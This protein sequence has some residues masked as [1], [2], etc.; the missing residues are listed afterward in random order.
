MQQL[1]G[2]L[3][4]AFVLWLGYVAATAQEVILQQEA[5]GTFTF[6]LAPEKLTLSEFTVQNATLTPWSWA[7][8]VVVEVTSLN[9]PKVALQQSFDAWLKVNGFIYLYTFKEDR[10][11]IKVPKPLPNGTIEIASLDGKAVRVVNYWDMTSG[12]RTKLIFIVLVALTTLFAFRVLNK[13]RAMRSN[14]KV[15]TQDG[16]D[17]SKL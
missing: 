10:I 8:T 13:F 17:S 9:P 14:L 5:P 4:V 16:L 3:M 12:T 1:K 11:R 2:G 7:D 6:S 15:N